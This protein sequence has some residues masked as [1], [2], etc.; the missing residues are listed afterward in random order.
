MSLPAGQDRG[1]PD[2]AHGCRREAPTR[3]LMVAMRHRRSLIGP[4]GLTLVALVACIS[5]AS[6]RQVAPPPPL[7]PRPPIGGLG[8]APEIGKGAGF[9]LGQTVDAGT[10]RAVAGAIVTLTRFGA[11]PGGVPGGPLAAVPTT[12]EGLS[13]S[14]P[15][16]VISDG[17]GRFLFRELPGG[18]Y[19]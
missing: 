11:L 19:G 4:V 1:Y 14:A 10:G 3:C 8:S 12:S 7:P 16:R 2:R 6:A 17:D 15:R 5:V 9:I 13:P 18:R